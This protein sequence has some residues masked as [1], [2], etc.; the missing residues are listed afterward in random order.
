MEFTSAAAWS[1]VML[2][3]AAAFPGGVAPGAFWRVGVV[4]PL[5]SHEDAP[6]VVGLPLAPGTTPP[7]AFW[8]SDTSILLPPAPSGRAVG[9]AAAGAAPPPR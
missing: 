8:A 4:A 6:P 5:G 3:G 1:D 7:F 2:P 9:A